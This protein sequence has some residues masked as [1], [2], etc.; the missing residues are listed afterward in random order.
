MQRAGAIRR[1]HI[2]SPE[3]TAMPFTQWECLLYSIVA[4]APFMVLYYT[5]FRDEFRYST[6]RTILILI[7][8]TL[9]QIA[10]EF[11]ALYGYFPWIGLAD[12]ISPLLFI[13]LLRI[14]L[15][16][17]L[18]RIFFVLLVVCNFSNLAVSAAKYVEGLISESDALKRYHWTYSCLL[19]FFEILVCLFLWKTIFQDFRKGI[20]PESAASEQ[21]YAGDGLSGEALPEHG[22]RFSSVLG[23]KDEQEEE[24][25]G[26]LW[27]YLF[28]VPATFYLVW[29]YMFYQ[30]SEPAVRKLMHLYYLVTISAIDFGSLLVY[31]LIIRLVHDQAEKLALRSQNYRL[32]LQAVQTQ[33]LSDRIENTRRIRHDMRHFLATVEMMANAGEWDQLRTYIAE[34]RSSSGIDEPLVFCDNAAVNAVLSYFAPKMKENG[35]QSD[36][37]IDMPRDPGISS[38]DLS[39][40][41][42]NL[43]ENAIEAC[44]HQASTERRIS[45]HSSCRGDNTLLITCANTFEIEPRTDKYGTYLSSKRQGC[46]IGIESVRTIVRRYNG[47]CSITAKDKIFTVRIMLL[48]NA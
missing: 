41:F 47:R 34:T 45:I 27:S 14:I 32:Q 19:L 43:T 35:I 6:R 11:N 1:L 17:P 23:E 29:M 46:G 22:Y 37:Q 30:G 42:A 2:L 10:I 7:P 28:L 36:I 40:L 9:V 24:D 38:S 21:S 48:T 25:N 39:I 18:G 12:I 44:S 20:R 33:Y 5:A 3:D 15:R 26:P 8:F 16:G 31:R 13:L 4:I